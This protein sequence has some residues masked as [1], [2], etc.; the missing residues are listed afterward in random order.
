MRVRIMK[1]IITAK[2]S[3]K[4]GDVA[5]VNKKIGKG[6]CRA[7]IACQ[8]ASLNGGEETKRKLSLKREE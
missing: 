3:F 5:N 2:G 6:W 1:M 7:G 4:P 8:D